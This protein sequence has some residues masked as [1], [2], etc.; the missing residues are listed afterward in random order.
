MKY[1]YFNYEG[2]FMKESPERG[3]GVFSSILVPES[4]FQKARAKFR[5]RLKEDQIELVETIDYFSV[6]ADELDP[7]DTDNLVWIEWHER[8]SKS[9]DLESDVWHIYKLGT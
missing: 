3:N 4:D 2:E 1:W 9:G 7:S 5:R 8:A 6:D